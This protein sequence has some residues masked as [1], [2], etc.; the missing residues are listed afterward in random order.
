ML[1]ARLYTALLLGS[2]LVRVRGA[3]DRLAEENGKRLHYLPKGG[4]YTCQTAV[5]DLSQLVQGQETSHQPV[6][7]SQSLTPRELSEPQLGCYIA[8]LFWGRTS[9]LP[10]HIKKP[11]RG[12]SSPH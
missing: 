10:R 11:E 12:T 2:A 3:L 5:A 6:G 8:R 9:L 7:A 4:S 1:A